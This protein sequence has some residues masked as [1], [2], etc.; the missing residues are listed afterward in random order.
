MPQWGKTDAYTNS[1]IWAVAGYNATPNTGA[2]SNRQTFYDNVSRG[3]FIT[4]MIVGQ[5]GVDTTEVAVNSGNVAH[6]TVTT[7]GSGYTANV[8]VTFTATN[9]GSGAAANAVANSIGRIASVTIVAN[10]AGYITNPT[11]TIP[12]PT[13]TTFNANTAVTAGPGGGANSVITISSAGAFIA[14]DYATYTVATGNTAIA[15][16]VSG[17][18]YAIQFAN[19][20]VVALAA[21]V[22]GD[23]ITIAKGLTQTGHSLQGVTATAVATVGGGKNRGIPHAGWV[24][25]K[26]GTGGRAGRVQY[27][28]LVAM[29]SITSDGSDDLI[30]P[31]A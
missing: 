24:V 29:S 6:I 7:N 8:G 26:V 5:F 3:S 30:L 12:A 17:T 25:R 9:G 15:N 20:T 21:T 18:V 22:G 28:T 4:N 27:E 11:I 19:S 16:L 10:G 1:V 31:D 14:G 2:G 23:R 13:A